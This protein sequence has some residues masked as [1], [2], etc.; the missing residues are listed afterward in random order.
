MLNLRQR[1]VPQEIPQE[2]HVPISVLR[3]AT[4]V[5]LKTA[6]AGNAVHCVQCGGTGPLNV[7]VLDAGDGF[8]IT[9]AA[10]SNFMMQGRIDILQITVDSRKVSVFRAPY[11]PE[12]ECGLDEMSEALTSAC[13]LIRN[14]RL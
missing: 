11:G 10:K 8:T 9:V 14:W 1:S 5:A 2:T 3:D 4:I 7:S 12:H 6:A 13:D